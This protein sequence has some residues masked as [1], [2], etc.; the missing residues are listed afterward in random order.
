MGV[1]PIAITTAMTVAIIIDR[2]GPGRR[3]SL[4]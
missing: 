1:S 2:N 3:L 4:A